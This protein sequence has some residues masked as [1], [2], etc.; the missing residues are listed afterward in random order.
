V[1]STPELEHHLARL[2][3]QELQL[4][5]EESQKRCP[6]HA[7]ICDTDMDATNQQTNTDKTASN[8]KKRK[9]GKKKRKKK[10]K[11]YSVLDDNLRSLLSKIGCHVLA[12]ESILVVLGHALCNFFFFFL[13]IV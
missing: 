8:L 5:T 9:R 7:A 11:S 13:R 12:L 2:R 6:K 3:R 1:L 4:E 10:K